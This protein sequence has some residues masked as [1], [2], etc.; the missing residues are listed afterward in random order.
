MKSQEQPTIFQV[1]V[2]MITSS[3]WR[4]SKQNRTIVMRRWGSSGARVVKLG[5]DVRRRSGALPHHRRRLRWR[6]RSAVELLTRRLVVE[7]R[8]RLLLLLVRV[9]LVLL[10]LRI[11][12]H[13]CHWIER[14]RETEMEQCKKLDCREERKTLNPKFWLG[15]GKKE[16][17]ARRGKEKGTKLGTTAFYSNLKIF[18]WTS[19]SFKEIDIC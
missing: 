5:G 8:R 1:H 2:T 16:P 3:N 9:L 18:Q 12:V 10:M 7:M 6:R 15:L 19:K 4:K 14:E 11:I 13:H 17:L